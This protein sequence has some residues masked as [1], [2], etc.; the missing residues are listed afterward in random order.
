MSNSEGSSSNGLMGGQQDLLTPTT[1]GRP[2]VAPLFFSAGEH[3]SIV[4]FV[5]TTVYGTSNQLPRSLPFSGA[6]PAAGSAPGGSVPSLGG[7]GPDLGGVITLLLIALL[8]GKFVWYAHQFLKPNSA[9]RLLI[10]QPG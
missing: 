4:D 6:L 10:N 2:A 1:S 8:G 5:T 3:S 7:A 9:F